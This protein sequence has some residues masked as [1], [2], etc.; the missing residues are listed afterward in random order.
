MTST[1]PKPASGIEEIEP[2]EYASS[3]PLSLWSRKPLLKLDC[4]E[5]TYPPSPLVKRKL[6]EFIENAPLNWYPDTGAQ[7]LKLAVS[8]Y[9]EHPPEFISIFNG[10]DH[11][12]ETLCRTYLK[13]GDEVV[14][15]APTYDNFRV[16]AESAGGSVIP[17]Y[18]RTPFETNVRGIEKVFRPQTK[19]VYLANPTNPTGVT[20]NPEE[21]LHVLKA[22][23]SALVIVDE[24]YYE[25][26]GETSLSLI[27]DHPNLVVTRSFSKAFALAGLRCGYLVSRP[28]NIRVIEKVRNGKNV[29]VLAQVAASAA[30]EDIDFI[31]ARIQ[32][33][34]QAKRWFVKKMT[35]RGM[36]VIDTPANFVLMKVPDPDG[37]HKALE[38]HQ[39]LVRNRN[40][41]PQLSGYLRITIGTS[42]EMERLLSTFQTILSP[43]LPQET[44]RPLQDFP[45]SSIEP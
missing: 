32:E 31:R 27:R 41:L 5:A 29:N 4:N 7:D 43:R 45:Y 25:F 6:I 24:A 38:S 3:I 42:S 16:F 17:I 28:E 30:L 1:A 11:A 14:I 10:C 44:S 23:A 2:Y 9:V 34:H 20:Y 36:P 21:I 39:V 37:V 26:W 8:R 33:L 35:Q 40:T 12:L 18:A 19:I 13:K 15:F 22:A